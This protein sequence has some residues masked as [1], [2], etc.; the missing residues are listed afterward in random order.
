[1]ICE[2]DCEVSEGSGCEGKVKAA[3]LPLAQ[4]PVVRHVETPLV[5][6]GT[7]PQNAYEEL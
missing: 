3:L 2:T 4:F 6:V 5:V 7:V 1:M